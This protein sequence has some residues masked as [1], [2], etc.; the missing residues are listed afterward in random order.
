MI[1]AIPFIMDLVFLFIIKILDL[2]HKNKI[3]PV[4]N[5]YIYHKIVDSQSKLVQ[6]PQQV[7][8]FM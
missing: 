4:N 5:I 3:I 1:T 8:I 2:A 7:T 6:W